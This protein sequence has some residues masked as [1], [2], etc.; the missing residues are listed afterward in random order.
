MTGRLSSGQISAE[1]KTEDGESKR[2]MSDKPQLGRAQSRDHTEARWN[3]EG[4]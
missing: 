4:V 3:L 2:G 1:A